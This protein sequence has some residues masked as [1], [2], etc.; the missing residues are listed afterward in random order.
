MDINI[1]SKMRQLIED[2]K[3]ADK[4][5]FEDD[6]PICTDRVYDSMYNNLLKLEASTG[7]IYSD[8][9]TQR[10]GGQAV[11]GLAKVIHSTPML[12]CDKTKSAAEM[13]KFAGDNLVTVSWK[14]DGLTIVL[15][16]DKGQLFQIITRGDGF[17]GE[18]VTHNAAAFRNIPLQIPTQEYVEIRGEGVIP[19]D[20]FNSFNQQ[21]GDLYDHPRNLAAGTVR[22]FDPK[23]AAKRHLYFKAFELVAP[24]IRSKKKQF[25]QMVD[26]G[27]D[28]V[29]YTTYKYSNTHPQGAYYG[30]GLQ[31]DP[32]LIRDTNNDP[33]LLVE[34]NSIKDA[35]NL[36]DP[37]KYPFPVDGL[38]AEFDDTDY[39]R[40]LGSTKHHRRCQMAYKWADEA[41][42]THLTGILRRVTRTGMISLRAQFEP[43]RIEYSTVEKATLHNLDIFESLE[44]GIGD[45]IEVYKANKIIPAIAENNTRSGTYK[46]PKTCPACGGK[47]VEKQIVNTR[48]LFCENPACRKVSQLQHFCSKKAA[49]IKGVSESTLTQF[50]VNGIID[51]PV[52]LYTKLKDR[53]EDIL[54]LPKMGEQKYQAI[55]DAVE[56]SRDMTMANFLVCLDIPMLGSSAGELLE[57]R[58][59]G[60]IEELIQALD[61][62]YDFRLLSGVGDVLNDN[63]YEW[64]DDIQNINFF[65][66]LRRSV[67]IRVPAGNGGSGVLAGKV[68]VVTGTLRNY[69]R[70]EAHQLIVK[71]GG[72]PADSVTKKTDYLV[73]ADN[74]PG[75]TKMNKAKKLG[76][77]TLTEAQFLAM[78]P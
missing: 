36:F 23:E 31:D 10:V 65:N 15:R 47:L 34:S 26:W 75:A 71:N 9:P 14:E 45:E 62:H 49:N 18:D 52:D 46:L 30:Y 72:I 73:I 7:I 5:Y 53:K 12:S 48:M 4:A 2:I 35:L 27:F 51:G 54:K 8:S 28:V 44:L 64:L 66:A 19:W 77:P 78:L 25:E 17:E 43:V 21:C 11:S 56:A 59:H 42:K 68:I 22:K 61:N 69:T 20:E 60:K 70:S 39:G 1:K 6:C 74:A 50:L 13:D 40:T 37:N 67:R 16:Y 24:K 55:V 76:T 3:A 41:V 57:K 63:I 29:E 33:I 32:L 58:F 38:V